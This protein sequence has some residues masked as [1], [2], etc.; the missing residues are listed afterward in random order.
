MSWL[1]N[2]VGTEKAVENIMDKD[3]GL[4]ARFGGWV[5]DFSYTDAEKAEHTRELREWGIR[6]L[7]ALHPFKVTQRVLAFIAA[8][9]WVFLT[10]NIVAAVWLGNEKVLNALLDFATSKYAA[11]PAILA[12]GLYF[13][14]GAIES[15]KRKVGQVAK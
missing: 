14:G 3:R 13:G 9:V 8:G 4:L 7:E 11:M 2:L 1:G 15:F 10:V 12:Y 6:Q 5:N